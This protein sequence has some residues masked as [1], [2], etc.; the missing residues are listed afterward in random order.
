MP[1][2]AAEPDLFPNDLFDA[3]PESS[4]RCWWA[5]YTMARQEKSLARQMLQYRI[6]FYLPLVARD[7]TIRGR[8]IRSYVPLFTGYLFLLASDEERVRALATHR[9]SRVFPVVDGEEFWR[10]LWQVHSLIVSGA[11]M[12]VEQRLTPGRRVRVTCGPMMGLEG[13]VISRRGASRL[14]VRVNFLQQGASIAIDDFMLEPL[15]EA[16]AVRP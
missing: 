15:D 3:R 11:P 12:T 10:D 1:I 8:R 16:C 6:P 13:T 4:D 7:N 14:L 2:L 9:I 5:V